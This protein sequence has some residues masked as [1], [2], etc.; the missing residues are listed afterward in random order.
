MLLTACT[1]TKNNDYKFTGESDHWEAEFAYKGTEKWGGKETYTNEDSD[2][3]RLKY[4]GSLEELS[5]LKKLYYSYETNSRRGDSNQEFT[6]PPSTVTF[7]TSS[8]SNGAMVREDT[9]IK[10]NVKWDEFEESFELHNKNK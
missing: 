6:E 10:V 1:E 8:S 9:V 4:K 3:F 5:S 2:E 7:S